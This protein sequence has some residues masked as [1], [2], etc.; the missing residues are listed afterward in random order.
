MEWNAKRKTRGPFVPCSYQVPR[1]AKSQ[2]T[3]DKLFEYTN[4]Y[5]SRSNVQARSHNVRDAWLYSFWYVEALSELTV[6]RGEKLQ[7]NTRRMCARK[8]KKEETNTQTFVGQAAC[9][10][11]I[12]TEAFQRTDAESWKLHCSGIC[13]KWTMISES[14]IELDTK[15]SLFLGIFD[16][17]LWTCSWSARTQS[18]KYRWSIPRAISWSWGLESFTLHTWSRL[19]ARWLWLQAPQTYFSYDRSL[20]THTLT[21]TAAC[22]LRVRDIASSRSRRWKTG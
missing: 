15:D 2:R 3:H 13:C 9:L 22:V 5:G 10:Y 16:F 18:K 17:G 7:T 14:R 19:A 11:C 1:C 20:I 21:H 8:S 4:F 6:G 12:E